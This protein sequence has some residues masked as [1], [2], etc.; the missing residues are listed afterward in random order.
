MSSKKQ[1]QLVFADFDEPEYEALDEDIKQAILKEA[2]H[3]ERVLEL[4]DGSASVTV[5]FDDK[6]LKTIRQWLPRLRRQRGIKDATQIGRGDKTVQQII[7]AIVKERKADGLSGA[8]LSP[9]VYEEAEI[10]SNVSAQHEAEGRKAL[11]DVVTWA[12]LRDSVFMTD[13][14]RVGWRDDLGVPEIPRDYWEAVTKGRNYSREDDED[15]LDAIL[16]DVYQTEKFIPRYNR[17]GIETFIG[18]LT[19][20]LENNPK[21][22][23]KVDEYLGYVVLY[24]GIDAME[25]IDDAGF[26][27]NRLDAALQRIV[28]RDDERTVDAPA[29]A[30]AEPDTAAD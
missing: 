30:D 3:F 10:I 17:K 11:V 20:L 26:L 13:K 7:R 29:R 8:A 14:G 25:V 24:V 12:M 16:T 23:R 2:L 27:K 22:R 1:Q 9:D 19:I 28:G 15:E 6:V 4:D 18:V 21:L 5:K